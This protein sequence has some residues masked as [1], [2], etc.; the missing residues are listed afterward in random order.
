[1]IRT[2]S[3]A[4]AASSLALAASGATAFAQHSPATGKAET[5]APAAAEFKLGDGD[6][7]FNNLRQQPVYESANKAVGEIEDVVMDASGQVRAI[8]VDIGLGGAGRMIALPVS[9][10]EMRKGVPGGATTRQVEL[11]LKGGAQAI[12]NAQRYVPLTER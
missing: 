6:I 5:P 2:L 11:Y 1:V 8:I 7:T 10:F 12:Q 9:A 4:V 3:F